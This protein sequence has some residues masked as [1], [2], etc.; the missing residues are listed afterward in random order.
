VSA[1]LKIDRYS[2]DSEKKNYTALCECGEHKSKSA[3]AC[4]LCTAQDGTRVNGQVIDL[5]RGTDGMS[6]NEVS[7]A[8][9]N[10]HPQGTHRA[11][12]RLLRLGRVRRYWREADAV[13]MD[14][15]DFGQRRKFR[16][17]VGNG[18]WVYA[19]DGRTR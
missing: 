4:K 3:E 7:R 11:L 10:Q 16:R 9:G 17:V 19:L 5:L 8:L 2:H 13:E 14:A 12:L 18:S 6:V 15:V 1:A